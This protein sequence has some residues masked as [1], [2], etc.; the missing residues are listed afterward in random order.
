MHQS[1][2]T[3]LK[4]PTKNLLTKQFLNG[5]NSQTI[6]PILKSSLRK[7]N[8]QSRLPVKHGYSVRFEKEFHTLF[9]KTNLQKGFKNSD[10]NYLEKRF[11]PCS[12]NYLGGNRAHIFKNPYHSQYGFYDP[13]MTIENYTNTHNFY[14]N[15]FDQGIKSDINFNRSNR[16]NCQTQLVNNHHN[17]YK[18][19]KPSFMPYSNMPPHT[20]QI[21][22]NYNFIGVENIDPNKYLAKYG[23]ELV[24]S[25]ELSDLEITK[26][27]NSNV[28]PYNLR[29]ASKNASN[30]VKPLSFRI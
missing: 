21:K 10:C 14:K 9:P 29:L 15:K 5:S 18:Q 26:W 19:V 17:K 23:R 28:L 12:N 25:Y 20:P 22:R 7:T 13:R 2:S 16:S 11:Q 8:F 3:R 27:A 24:N 4:E 1:L 30:N 6:L